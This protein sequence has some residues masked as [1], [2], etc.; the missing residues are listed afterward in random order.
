MDPFFAAVSEGN[1]AEVE[2]VIEADGALVNAR[3]QRHTP[4]MLAA[5]KGHEA[6]VRRLLEL[7]ADAAAADGFKY[8]AVSY[9][10][11]GGHASIL[12]MLLDAGA[13]LYYID[14][15]PPLVYVIC[16]EDE[17]TECA[18]VLLAHGADPN[19]YDY[20]GGGRLYGY[21]LTPLHYAAQKGRLETVRL[22]LRATAD[23]TIRTRRDWR[24]DKP[25][26]L[27]V[28]KGHEDCAALLDSAE[29]ARALVKARALLDATRTITKARSDAAAAGEAEEGQR[30]RAAAV[31]PACLKERVGE[32]KKL[33]VVKPK[34]PARR[35]RED[36]KRD[37]AVVRYV[38][39]M[40]GGEDGMGLLPELF[41]ELRQMFLVLK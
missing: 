34:D 18:K 41:E 3:S 32:G 24:G 31:A 35:S 26:D 10:C 13:P 40:E 29:R 2:R 37:A 33:P 8:T 28:R 38:L 15:E 4:L 9:A 6:V 7:G 25:I 11:K 17:Q 39:G 22:L 20:S 14:G 5:R 21:F 30:A 12:T 19:G 1:L 16:R 23:P 36:S 27:A